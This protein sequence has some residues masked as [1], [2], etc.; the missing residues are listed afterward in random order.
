MK[1]INY[2]RVVSVGLFLLNV[3]FGALLLFVGGWQGIVNVVFAIVIGFQLF[4][5]PHLKSWKK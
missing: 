1:N 3:V 4:T 2:H 5:Y